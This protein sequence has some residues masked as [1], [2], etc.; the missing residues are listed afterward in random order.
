MVRV[1]RRPGFGAV[2][3]L[4]LFLRGAAGAGKL[5]K[6]ARLHRPVVELMLGPQV[7]V[8]PAFDRLVAAAS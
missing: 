8:H 6:G 2:E 7:I 4:D 1:S 3:D 5:R